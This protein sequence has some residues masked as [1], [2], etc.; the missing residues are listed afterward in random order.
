MRNSA[1]LFAIAGVTFLFTGMSQAAP[2]VWM[3]D[4]LFDRA[5]VVV[6][7]TIRD[8]H[9]QCLTSDP[10]ERCVQDRGSGVLH[11]ERVLLG[12]LPDTESVSIYWAN[13]FVCPRT[14]HR[15][16]EGKR[17]LWFMRRIP[18]DAYTSSWLLIEN[19]GDIDDAYASSVV[20]VLGDDLQVNDMLQRLKREASRYPEYFRQI[21]TITTFLEMRE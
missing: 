18:S 4:E 20:L 2:G 9:V 6:V 8:V 3:V 7:G 1:L 10:P 13:Q 5:D 11:V 12:S 19:E 14:D 17:A 21:A 15:G 16:K